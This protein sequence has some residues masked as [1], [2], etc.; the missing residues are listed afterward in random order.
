MWNLPGPGVKY[1]FAVSVGRFL[2]YNVLLVFA[3]Q[4]ESAIIILVSPPSWV[5]FP[6]PHPRSSQ[7]TRLGSLCNTATSHWLS[8]L[9]TIVY[10]CLCYFLHL[11]HSLLNALCPWVHSL[12]LHLYSFPANRFIN[13]IFLDSIYMCEYTIFVF[14]FLTSF[15]L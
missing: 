13:T 5:C 4:H 2:L 14:L 3:V 10:I 12:C 7:S 15:I 1:M 9:H 11:P 6:S 8:I